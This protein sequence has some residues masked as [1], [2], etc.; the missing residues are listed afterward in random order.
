MKKLIVLFTLLTAS[1]FGQHH[2]GFRVGPPP[3]PPVVI[4]HSSPSVHFGFNYGYYYGPYGYYWGYPYYYVPTAPNPCKKETLKDSNNVKHD[5]LVCR[6]P[7]GSFKVV[8]DAN[9]P[10]PVK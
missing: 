8:A 6:E 2:G 5:V 4:Y 7:D 3:R 10:A 9:Q 1:L